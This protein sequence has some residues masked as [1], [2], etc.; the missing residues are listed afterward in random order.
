MHWPRKKTSLRGFV[1]ALNRRF[2]PGAGVDTSVHLASASLCIARKRRSGT[3]LHNGLSRKNV[4][5][6][7]MARFKNAQE[8]RLL[9]FRSGTTSLQVFLSV[10]VCL[11]KANR[12]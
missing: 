11:M 9:P 8:F 12:Q 7:F 1:A 10:E 2:Y 5:T 6:A 4:C 3:R